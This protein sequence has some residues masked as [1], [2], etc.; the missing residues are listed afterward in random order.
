MDMHLNA[1]VECSD[2]R[3][4]R[5][6]NIILNPKTERVTYLVVRGNDLQ[7]TERLVPERLVKEA[8]MIRFFFRS[9]RINSRG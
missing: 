8:P 4:G 9:A 5:L 2:G 3:V 6:E 7:N 1:H